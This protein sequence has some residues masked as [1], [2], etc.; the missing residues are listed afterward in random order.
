MSQKCQQRTRAATDSL[1]VSLVRPRSEPAVVR[2][3]SRTSEIRESGNEGLELDHLF[4]RQTVAL[5]VTPTAA[6]S[7]KPLPLQDHPPAIA[8]L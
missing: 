8:L 5:A 1:G 7:L 2:P 6:L 3:D 4:V